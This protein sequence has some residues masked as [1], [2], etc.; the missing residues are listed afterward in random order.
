MLR[1]LLFASVGAIALGPVVTANAADI[2]EVVD[3]PASWN[4]TFSIDLVY[5]TRTSGKNS[6]IIED[7]VTGDPVL[8]SNDFRFGWAPGVDARINFDNNGTDIGLRFLGLLNFSSTATVTTPGI[9]NFPTDPP[10][11]GLG[12]ADVVS[13][14]NT[15]FN[16]LEL[17]FAHPQAHEGFFWGL[18]VVALND[19]MVNN[20][21][22]GGNEAAITTEARSIGIGPQIGAEARFGDQM[23]VNVDGR[24]GALLT[25][26]DLDFG[27]VQAIGP[28]FAASTVAFLTLRFVGGVASAFGQ[29]GTY[30]SCEY[31]M[32]NPRQGAGT[33]TLSNGAKYQAHIGS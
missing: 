15:S 4:T 7:T 33:C 9:W 11:F 19:K 12:V 16:S 31:Q 10:L 14:A 25:Q 24:V 28:A 18:R 1:G 2:G 20:A 29:S 26:S 22:F 30:M 13:T 17:N 21:D 3:Y 6:V 8:T 32:S 5:A 23:F 27:V